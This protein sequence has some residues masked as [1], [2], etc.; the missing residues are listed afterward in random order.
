MESPH[1]NLHFFG[2]LAEIT[3]TGQLRYPFV[4]DTGVLLEQLHQE[5]PGLKVVPFQVAVNLH[6]V[7]GPRVLEPGM[8][9]ALLPPFSGG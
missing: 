9:I 8:D 4:T 6:I 1:L 3:G 7:Q 2:I 5:W